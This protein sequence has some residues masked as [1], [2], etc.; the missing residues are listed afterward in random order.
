M[1]LRSNTNT[2]TNN[3]APA[4]TSHQNT[5]PD[6]CDS[7]RTFATKIC[8]L[9]ERYDK[10]LVRLEC[11]LK[12]ISAALNI[13]QES[14]TNIFLKNDLTSEGWIH[15]YTYGT[16]LYH[17]GYHGHVIKE[18]RL[19]VIFQTVIDGKQIALSVTKSDVGRDGQFTLYQQ[20]E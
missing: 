6:V 10:R 2:T 8:T 13:D 17:A 15:E 3:N 4:Q 1:I 11:A 20:I 14:S 16:R 19:R 7:D 12:Q 18:T 5:H 9:M